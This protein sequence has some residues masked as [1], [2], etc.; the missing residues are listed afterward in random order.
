MRESQLEEE[1]KRAEAAYEGLVQ[2]RRSL[3]TMLAE[4][5][6]KGRDLEEFGL[7]LRELPYLTRQA[8]LR[9]TE[10]S[11]ALFERRAKRAEDEYQRAAEEA[12]KAARS[13]EQAREAYAKADK[14][15]RCS[16]LEARRLAELRDKEVSRLQELRRTTENVERFQGEGRRDQEQRRGEQ[17]KPPGVDQGAREQR[18][19]EE[20]A[21]DARQ[22]YGDVRAPSRAVIVGEGP[23]RKA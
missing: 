3:G 14:A 9:R 7:H 21:H 22:A 5:I 20:R 1:L 4:T 18:Q 16:G 13:L 6:R 19:S 8:D 17:E 23:N 2:T 11:H 12:A 10:L 15:A